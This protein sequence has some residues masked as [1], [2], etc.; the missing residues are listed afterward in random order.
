MDASTFFCHIKSQGVWSR[1]V[2][3]INS[4]HARNIIPLSSI[5]R[6]VN[7]GASMYFWH[8]SWNGNSPLKLQF[9][10]LFRLAT[11]KDCMIRDNWN[12]G[13]N[14]DWVR[15]ISS[16]SAASQLTILQNTLTETILNNSEDT[17]VWSVDPP[18][19]SVKSARCLIDAGL[20]PH[21]GPKTRWNKLLPKK[22]NIFLWRM[23]RDRLP[24]RWNLSRKGLEMSSMNCSLCDNGIDNAYHVFLTCSLAS[25]IWACIFKWLDI[26]P[27]II[28]SLMD[29]FVWLDDTRLSINKRNIIDVISGATFWSLWSFR[30]ESI[31]GKD[32]PKRSLL[33]DKIV[34]FSFRWHSSRCK[35]HSITWNNWIQNPLVVFSL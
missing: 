11:N 13:W 25:S 32:P 30:N 9:P 34:D 33:F 10:R 28:S 7:N 6:V 23:L 22:V 20:L 21:S 16:G 14:I 4:M 15:N 27:P 1:I 18:A 19:F 26:H 31:F 24:T 3:S 2:S 35:T 5:Q 29:F 12:N 8:D 17:Y